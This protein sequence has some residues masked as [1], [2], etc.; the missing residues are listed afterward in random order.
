M[1]RIASQQH[2]VQLTR[3]QDYSNQLCLHVFSGGITLL[4]V[5]L[6]GLQWFGQAKQVLGQ[7][8]T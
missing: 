8:L 3:R 1:P 4:L 6:I 5:F 2:R 7:L